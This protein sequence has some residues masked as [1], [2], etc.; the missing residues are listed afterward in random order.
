MALFN[1]EKQTYLVPADI[2]NSHDWRLF[3]E[4]ATQADLL[5]T[6]GRYIRQLAKNKAQDDLPVSQKP[7]YADLLEW[8]KSQN[9]PPQ[10]AV[11]ILSGSLDFSI[12]ESLLSSGRQIYVATGSKSNKRR[13]KELD[14][15]GVNVIIAGHGRH[16][17]GEWL[18]MEL[19]KRGFKT[20]EMVAGSAALY[21]LM[22]A[23][24]LSRL[25]LTYSF[26]A[27]GGN[28]FDTILKGEQLSPPAGFTL[29]SLYYDALPPQEMNQLFAVYDVRQ[30]SY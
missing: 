19:G 6:S 2:A 21:T 16:V 29:H 30:S 18:I 20:I 14:A 27:L 9:L 10:P 23:G 3:Q 15:N 22:A 12:P 11:V 1:P 7:E 13:R 5:I 26:K 24:V 25:Y 8:R 28:T 17:E 4:L